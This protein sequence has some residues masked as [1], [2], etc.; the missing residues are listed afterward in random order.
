MTATLKLNL[1][2][3][4]ELKRVIQSVPFDRIDLRTYGSTKWIKDDIADMAGWAGRDPWFIRQGFHMEDYAAPQSNRVYP[5]FGEAYAHYAT[6]AFFGLTDEQNEF[7]FGNYM[8][9]PHPLVAVLL[10]R[11]DAVMR[12]RM[13][14]KEEV[15]VVMD[16]HV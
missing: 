13:P 6:R 5:K 11:I 10:D 15:A 1:R 7:L 16:K 2:A 8:D 3:L 14:V 9:D 12:G 4:Q